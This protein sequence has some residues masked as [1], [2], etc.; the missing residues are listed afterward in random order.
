MYGFPP[1]LGEDGC[2]C[3]D[4]PMWLSLPV[5]TRCRSLSEISELGWDLTES[6]FF[7]SDAD[8]EDDNDAL[9]GHTGSP[10]DSLASSGDI[11]MSSMIPLSV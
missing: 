7:N 4:A 8:D 3:C 9:V 5:V 6:C 1:P 10:A 2:R 11:E